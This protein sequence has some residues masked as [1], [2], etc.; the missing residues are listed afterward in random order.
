MD[1]STTTINS[2]LLSQYK[3]IRLC[4][5][6]GRTYTTAEGDAMYNFVTAGG[7]LLADVPF[8]NDVPISSKY[9]VSTI[10]GQNGGSSGLD[11]HY[12]G[13]P[14]TFGPISGPVGTLNSMACESMDR[15]VLISGH[16]LTIDAK[17]DNYPAIVHGTFGNGKVVLTFL[18]FWA[19]DATYPGNAYRANIYQEQNLQFLDN[20]SIFQLVFHQRL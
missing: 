14:L 19:H 8:T 20:V 1:L 17:I 11:W 18:A 9:G 13:A 6:K 16:N 4:S 10:Q 12:H 15:P 7:K 2:S 5:Y 3:V